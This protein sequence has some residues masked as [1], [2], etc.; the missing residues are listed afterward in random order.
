[1]NFLGCIFW[2]SLMTYASDALDD[3]GQVELAIKV[4]E[5]KAHQPWVSIFLKGIGANFMVRS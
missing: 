1:M 5:K 2:A 4:A 3:A